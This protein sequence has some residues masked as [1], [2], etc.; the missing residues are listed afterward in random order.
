MLC[1]RECYFTTNSVHKKNDFIEQINRSSGGGLTLSLRD[2]EVTEFYHFL[3]RRFSFDD[4]NN[5]K[6]GSA[7]VGLQENGKTWILSS[8]LYINEDGEVM[9]KDQSDFVWLSHMALQNSGINCDIHSASLS[10]Q[11]KH[12][13]TTKD[14]RSL[15]LC[16]KKCFKHNFISSV[17]GISAVV[18]ALHYE[19]IIDVY[20]GCPIPYLYGCSQTG[21]TQTCKTA[22]AL[23]G[24][25]RKGFYKKS[26]SKKWFLDRCSMSSMP[27]II[28]DPR[29]IKDKKGETTVPSDLL[30]L[31]NDI[32]DGGIVANPR[33][34]A[35]RPRSL[36]MISS[37][38]LPRSDK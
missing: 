28:D 32:F 29:D 14:L 16:M 18:M 5:R 20:E 26:T 23:I 34:G 37:N 3:K 10:P 19:A 33:T 2:H 24:M 9:N 30:D 31:V 12:P 17:M 4:E 15:L 25:Q 8:A 38:A 7:V 35:I 27:F 22:L 6:R 36:C 13:L 1:F 21:K 11:V